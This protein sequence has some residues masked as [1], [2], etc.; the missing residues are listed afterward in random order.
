MRKTEDQKAFEKFVLEIYP[1]TSL[2]LD[3]NAIFKSGRYV[4]NNIQF[5]FDCWFESARQ[6]KEKH[7]G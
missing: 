2:H 3:W 7:R 1:Q 6:Q 4:N 5:G